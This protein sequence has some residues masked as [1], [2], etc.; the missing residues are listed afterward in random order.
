MIPGRI[1]KSLYSIIRG[2]P[3]SIDSS[4]Q[5][6][7]CPCNLDVLPSS[8]WGSNHGGEN[9]VVPVENDGVFEFKGSREFHLG[10]ILLANPVDPGLPTRLNPFCHIA[11]LKDMSDSNRNLLKIVGM[12][13]AAILVWKI[14]VAPILFI[15]KLLLP[16]AIV[17][18][19]VY[20]I[21]RGTGGKALG[22][23]RRTLP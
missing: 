5:V 8:L 6:I 10:S 23:G 4:F 22:G 1:P 15:A 21:Y 20:L 3:S 19:V 13:I 7:S 2:R 9:P 16:L 14:V 11:V 17:G 12:I 18:G